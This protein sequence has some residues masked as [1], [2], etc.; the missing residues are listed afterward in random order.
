MNLPIK[1]SPLFS[2][3][4]LPELLSENLR[5]VPLQKFRPKVETRHVTVH[6][7]VSEAQADGTRDNLST[8]AGDGDETNG[9]G[10]SWE[11]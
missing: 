7:I 5:L 2:R 4:F 11:K 8:G 6:L 1:S 9:G 10:E 3:K